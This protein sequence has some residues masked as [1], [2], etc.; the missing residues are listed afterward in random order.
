MVTYAE[1]PAP[2]RAVYPWPGTDLEVPGGRLHY[3]DE[4]PRDAPP[5]LFL[6]GNPTWSFYWRN[7]IHE[8]SSDHRCVAPD[9]LG[10]GLS[11]KPEGWSY[12][13]ADHIDNA[14][15]LVEALDLRGITLVV[16]DWGGAIGFGVAARLPDRIRRIVLF[17]T[18]AFH[19]PVPAEIRMCRW[20]VV[21]PLAI[22]GL[23]GFVRGGLWRATADRSRFAGAVAQGYLA[24]YPRWTDRVGHLKFIQD[25]PIEADH[26]TRPEIDALERALPRFRTTPTM[27]IWGMRDFCFTPAF[28][29]R[30]RQELPQAEVHAL[31]DAGHWVVEDAADRIGPWVRDF[32]ART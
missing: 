11:D 26:P 20:P 21:G 3:V 13:L 27:V 10:H 2:V 30:W 6:H 14:V 9:H 12:R 24:P 29:A 18:A 4:G 8:L 16:H 28:L 25:I 23:N 7:L 22:R 5:V 15:R 19:G 17:N 31:D 32:L 1:L